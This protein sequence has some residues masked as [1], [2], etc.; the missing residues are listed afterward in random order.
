MHTYQPGQILQHRDGNLR[1]PTTSV[2]VIKHVGDT[3]TV[4]HQ[5]GITGDWLSRDFYDPATETVN[6]PPRIGKMRDVK[7]DCLGKSW[8]EIEACQGGKLTRP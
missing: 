7:N 5:S 3:V 6:T 1:H 4:K 8:E 2:C